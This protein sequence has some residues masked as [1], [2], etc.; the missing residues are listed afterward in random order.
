MDFPDK[1]WLFL[2]GLIIVTSL[3]LLGGIM[4]P[5]EGSVSNLYIIPAGVFNPGSLLPSSHPAPLPVNTTPAGI[6][7]TATP[8]VSPSVPGPATMVPVTTGTL[9]VITPTNRSTL[10]VLRGEPFTIN[11]TVDNLR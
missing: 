1:K 2:I 8:P 9:P 7:T 4:S 6:V 10:N 5:K 3:V 11:G